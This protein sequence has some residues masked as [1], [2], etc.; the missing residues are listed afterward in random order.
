VR[1]K[2]CELI[3][4]CFGFGFVLCALCFVICDVWF[5]VWVNLRARH[6]LLAP[7]ARAVHLLAPAHT[8]MKD[9]RDLKDLTIHDVQPIGDE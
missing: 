3:V 2:G 5:V 6:L 9:L 4:C 1:I 7:G 8:E